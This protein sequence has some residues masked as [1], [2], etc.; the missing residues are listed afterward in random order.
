M[1]RSLV[2]GVI[3]QLIVM[4]Y[5]PQVHESAMKFLCQVA[6]DLGIGVK[7]TI[8]LIGEIGF[9]ADNGG[10]AKDDAGYACQAAY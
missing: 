5:L 6:D 8:L 1:P 9:F 3:L 7:I 2:S 4:K 10:R